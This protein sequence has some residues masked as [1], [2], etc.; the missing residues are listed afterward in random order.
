VDWTPEGVYAATPDAHAVLRWHVKR[1]W[2]APAEAIPVAEIP[3][4]HRPEVIRLVL[5]TLGTPPAIAVAELAKIRATIQRR[6]GTAVAP[7]PG[8]TC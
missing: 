5:Q 6:T 3:E 4:T 2:E 7:A 1:G 8:S